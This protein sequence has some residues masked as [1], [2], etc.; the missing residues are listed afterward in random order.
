MFGPIVSFA[1]AGILLGIFNALLGG[2]ASHKQVLAI[3]AHGGAVQLLQAAFTL[4]LNYLRESMSGATNLG[5]FAQPF[6]DD[7]SFAARFLGMIDLF[8]I[9]GLI[10]T[11]IG[12]AVL[13][14][15]QTTPIFWSLMGVYIL[16]AIGIAGLMRVTS[17]GA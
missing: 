16:I 3:L 2:N 1:I 8:I 14:K 12:L 11:A 4:P 17:G 15:R 9:W 5:V 10:V 7:T 6:L 13:F